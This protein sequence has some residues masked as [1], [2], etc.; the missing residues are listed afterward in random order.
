MDQSMIDRKNKVKMD[1][2]HSIIGDYE[3]KLDKRVDQ[4]ILEVNTMIVRSLITPKRSAIL[5]SC[6]PWEIKKFSLKKM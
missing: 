5:L 6:Q 2:L 1:R 3:A 4:V